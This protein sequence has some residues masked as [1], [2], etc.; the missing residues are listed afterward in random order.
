MIIDLQ[1]LCVWP[2]HR[3]R[4]AGG[5]LVEWGSR[6]ADELN[7]ICIVESSGMA[8]RLYERAGYVVEELTYVLDNERFKES[9]RDD[10][11]IHRFMVR[12]RQHDVQT[13]GKTK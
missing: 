8:Q 11:L 6:I 9:D 3:K 5:Q 12:P 1:I 13:D 7:A 10:T 2:E 4:G